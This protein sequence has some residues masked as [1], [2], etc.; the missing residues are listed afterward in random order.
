MSSP[1][2]HDSARRGTER[3]DGSGA[4]L[5]GFDGLDELLLDE[6]LETAV[7]DRLMQLGLGLEVLRPDACV[8]N[9]SSDAR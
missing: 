5:D 6:G 7:D 4:Y 2:R 3:R 1:L 9:A 8:A